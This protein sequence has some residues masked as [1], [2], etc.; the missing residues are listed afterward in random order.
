V[1]PEMKLLAE[2]AVSLGIILDDSQLEKFAELTAELLKWNRKINLTAIRSCHDVVV[3]HLLD[4]LTLSAHVSLH[5][6]LLDIG[7]GAG[8]PAIP[9]SMIRPDLE[10]DSVDAV[11]KKIL[12]QKHVA[13]TLKLGNFRA[14]HARVETLSRQPERYD[15]IVSRAFS[16]L[17][18]FAEY[19]LPLLTDEGTI[20]S[21]KGAGGKDEVLKS[22][23]ELVGMM[24]K[25]ERVVEFRL[26]IT[27]DGRMLIV[28]SK[29]QARN[30]SKI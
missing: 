14:L 22:E 25:V 13:R 26:P 8:F 19:S 2:G 30:G 5:G 27:G 24:I 12:F 28:M 4:S 18:T 17:K 10:V 16:S 15:F 23:S 29:K 11:Q 6:K 7:S 3:K 9:L 21:M 1:T 20:I